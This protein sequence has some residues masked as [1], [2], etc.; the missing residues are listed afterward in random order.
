MGIHRFAAWIK[1]TIVNAISETFPQII[2][3]TN[4]YLHI[5]GSYILH[6]IKNNVQ[7]LE[8]NKT[9][10][11]EKYSEEYW[12]SM[13]NEI[14]LLFVNKINDILTIVKTNANIV[15]TFIYFDGITP[16]PKMFHQRKRRYN[17]N[18]LITN[19]IFTA[20]TIFMG[21]LVNK[22]QEIFTIDGCNNQGE[23][24]IKIVQ[25]IKQ[26]SL[27]D[28]NYHLIINP[29]NDLIPILLLNN[30][31]NVC[32]MNICIEN[33]KYILICEIFNYLSNLYEN[34]AYVKRGITDFAFLILFLGND[35]LNSRSYIDNT[36]NFFNTIVYAYINLYKQGKYLYNNETNTI[37]W[38]NY[39]NIL[40]ILVNWE[41]KILTNKYRNLRN[42]R[43][44]WNKEYIIKK[45]LIK[46]KNIKSVCRKY[47]NILT[48]NIKYW[49]L[50]EAYTYQYYPYENVPL[51]YD[52]YAY[53]NLCLMKNSIISEDII[54]ECNINITA[55]YNFILFHEK[56]KHYFDKDQQTLMENNKNSIYINFKKVYFNLL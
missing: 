15:N 16:A 53:L 7:E 17:E 3:N 50:Q 33:H 2:V 21:K 28:N 8:A 40:G 14:Y 10:S 25:N 13:V 20:G 23:G 56:H 26:L 9:N 24:E 34:N 41:T 36:N 35:F 32:I 11:I 1:K 54:E 29:D 45:Y 12:D 46:D 37:N 4:C 38:Q 6:T 18:M 42:F 44:N 22:L 48:W 30:Q 27:I 31:V 49:S 19:T 5:D 52:L 55:Y 51:I 47:F 39:N 43:D